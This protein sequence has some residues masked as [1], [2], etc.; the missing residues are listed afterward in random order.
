MQ[1]TVV[2]GVFCNG[3]N[4]LSAKLPMGAAFGNTAAI[5]FHGSSYKEA[6]DLDGMGI[7]FLRQIPGFPEVGHQQKLFSIT[8][9]WRMFVIQWIDSHF[10]VL[11]GFVCTVFTKLQKT[12]DTTQQSC[13]KID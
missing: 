8:K 11:P 5:A 6:P 1:R 10:L 7:Q 13:H 3:S 12:V 4:I 2:V 9:K